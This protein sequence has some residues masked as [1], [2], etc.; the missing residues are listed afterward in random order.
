MHINGVSNTISNQQ[1]DPSIVQRNIRD[2]EKAISSDV[3][4]RQLRGHEERKYS[5]EEIIGAIESANEKF[6]A[7]DR[8]FEFSI[9]E[10][11]K[12]IMV[13][14]IDVTTDEVIREIPPEKILDMVAYIWESVGLI[15]DKK[16]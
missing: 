11:T 14:V 2:G 15:V 9:H 5:E 13:K 4:N 12:Q 16:I 10:K 8:R 1:Y 7:Y 6:V 3:G